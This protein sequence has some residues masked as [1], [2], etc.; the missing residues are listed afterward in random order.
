MSA[1]SNYVRITL[2]KVRL[3]V[4]SHI[5]RSL[6]FRVESPFQSISCKTSS[7]H[8]ASIRLPEKGRGQCPPTNAENG[9][10][11]EEEQAEENSSSSRT[12]YLSS[13]TISAK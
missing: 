11:D 13:I 8:L 7:Q 3:S 2:W 6:L 12:D 10:G 1:M 5:L 9:D 4:F